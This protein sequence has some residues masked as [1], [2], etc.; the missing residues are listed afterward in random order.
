VL[1]MTQRPAN[2]AR[3]SCASGLGVKYETTVAF[4]DNQDDLPTIRFGAKLF[5]HTDSPLQPTLAVSSKESPEET[6]VMM[7]DIHFF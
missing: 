4:D 3:H 6:M 7:N 2:W 1:P 5:G